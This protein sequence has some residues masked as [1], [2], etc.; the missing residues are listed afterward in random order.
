MTRKVGLN[1]IYFWYEYL[2][3][4]FTHVQEPSCKG[5]GY[6]FCFWPCF[7]LSTTLNELADVFSRDKF[8]K[9]VSIDERKQF[10]Q[11]FLYIAERVEIIRTVKQC[12]DP[13]DDKFLELALS[14]QADI[15]ITGDD[16]L[17]DMEVFYSTKI[18]T[19]KEFI[20]RFS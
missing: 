17:L 11:H 5:I 2:I 9:Y 8:D 3:Q 16:D 19:P 13:K 1:E 10:L 20:E 18:I 12:R 7:S 14:G 6:R 15:L 4:S